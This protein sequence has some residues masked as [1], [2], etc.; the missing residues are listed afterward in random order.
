MVVGRRGLQCLLPV[1]LEFL[2]PSAHCFYLLPEVPLNLAIQSNL[3]SIVPIA[4]II[5]IQLKYFS[6]LPSFSHFSVNT[7]QPLCGKS[8]SDEFMHEI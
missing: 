4:L 8:T 1:S 5:Q 7:L 6:L 3:Q 2:D